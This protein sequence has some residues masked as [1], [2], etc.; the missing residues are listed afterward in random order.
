MYR[1]FLHYL[2]SFSRDLFFSYSDWFVCSVWRSKFPSSCLRC[3]QWAEESRRQTSLEL[4]QGFSGYLNWCCSY[5]KFIT[6]PVPW[7]LLLSPPHSCFGRNTEGKL[8]PGSPWTLF[9]ESAKSA[10]ANGMS[11]KMSVRT[12]LLFPRQGFCYTNDIMW[13][14]K[15]RGKESRRN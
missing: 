1:R 10:K 2:R 12:V 4:A 3:Y 14:W 15:E 7:S 6:P 11:V 8:E 5:C 9:R 13:L